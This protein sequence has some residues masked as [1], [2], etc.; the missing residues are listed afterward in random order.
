VLTTR[1]VADP[2]TLPGHREVA[3]AQ[4]GFAGTALA[5]MGGP[6]G[7][8]TALRLAY[9]I[10]QGDR[11]TVQ[12]VLLLASGN[13]LDA[14][15]VGRELTLLLNNGVLDRDTTEATL[16]AIDQADG[17]QVV[18]RSPTTWCRR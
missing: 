5:R 7:A 17:G 18:R 1:R 11:D 13:D 8:A 2:T 12:A 4:G 3:A 15:L 10:G 16:A 9:G 14:A 6:F